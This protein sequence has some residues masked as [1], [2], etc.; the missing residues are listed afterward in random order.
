MQAAFARGWRHITHLYNATPPM[1][2]RE[3]GVV[4]AA[5]ANGD[6]CCELIAD[7]IHAHPGAISAALNAKGLD[8]VMLITD[9]M[10]AAGLGDG[11]YQIDARPVTVRNGA[12]RLADGTLAGS[13]LT[14]DAALRNVIHSCGLTLAQAWP[15]T[16][17]NAAR[18]LGLDAHTALAAGKAA[19]LV[20]LDAALNVALTIVGG[21][22]THTRAAISG[23]T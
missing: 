12:V 20:V 13:V 10:R 16:S 19:D 17:R 22:V 4:G 6:A 9:A 21:R 2:H 5:F 14:M 8:R 18:S 3:P 11:D 15:L 1:H 7:L 23:P